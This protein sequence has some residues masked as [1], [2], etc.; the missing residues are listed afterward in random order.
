MITSFVAL[1]N[2]KAWRLK[3][4]TKTRRQCEGEDHQTGCFR[5]WR[6]HVWYP[7]V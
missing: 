1:I 3:S 6:W 4:Q 2:P 5:V 7:S